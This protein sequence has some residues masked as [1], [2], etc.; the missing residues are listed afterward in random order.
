M[1]DNEG[2]V[3]MVQRLIESSGFEVRPPSGST[4]F[5]ESVLV[6]VASR[7]K[8]SW[9]EFDVYDHAGSQVAQMRRENPSVL[10]YIKGPVNMVDQRHSR[11][12]RIEPSFNP[13][14]QVFV[15]SGVA[16]VRVTASKFSNGGGMTIAGSDGTKIGR[17]KPGNLFGLRGSSMVV[18][19]AY[20]MPVGAIYAPATLRPRHI[21]VSISPGPAAPLRGAIAALPPILAMAVAKQSS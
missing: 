3:S 8:R 13:L 15:V 7:G 10:C 12:L 1:R 20:D 19:D 17:V 5:G 18:Q 6:F 14:R 2:P 21:V 9:P 11:V 16:G 4:L